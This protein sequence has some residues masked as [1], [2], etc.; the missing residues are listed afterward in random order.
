M[1]STASPG[2]PSNARLSASPKGTTNVAVSALRAGP[3]WV[4]LITG[5]LWILI[6]WIVLRFNYRSVAAIAVLAGTVILLAAIAEAYMAFTSPGWKWLH[7]IL[8]VL[9]LITGIVCFIHPGNTFF[10]LAAFIGWYLLFKGIADI[11][12]SFF[13]KSENDAWWLGL[14]VG[15]LEVMIGFWAAGRW[16]R[17][18]YLLIVFVGVIAL[19][20]GITDIVNAFRLRKQPVALDEAPVAATAT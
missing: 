7:G 14:I 9:F 11:M 16:G 4:F 2:I 10:W 6:A 8:A 12:L 3:W 13:T 20:R 17:S 15:I 5:P 19:A 1:S 18:A